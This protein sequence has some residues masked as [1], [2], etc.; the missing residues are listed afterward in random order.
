MICKNHNAQQ[1][2]TY[3]V[4][5]K[6]TT[7]YEREDSFFFF[8]YGVELNR[9]SFELE[10]SAGVGFDLNPEWP[11]EEMAAHSAVN[12]GSD[13]PDENR[14]DISRPATP[15]P[16][17]T[18]EEGTLR[19]SNSAPMF[20]GPN[21]TDD[22]PVFQPIREKPR[23]RRMSAQTSDGTKPVSMPVR[24]P[25]RVSQIKQEE[26]LDIMS[27]EAEHEREVRSAFRISQS[28][29]ELHLDE[30]IK[31]LR[32][33]T[34]SSLTEPLS[35]ITPVPSLPFAA[36]SP[37]PT[38]AGKQCFSPQ[39]SM[40]SPCMSPS[41]NPSPTRSNFTR[42]SMSPVL[43]PSSLTSSLKRKYDSD[44]EYTPSKRQLLSSPLHPTS[45]SMSSMS[46]DETSPPQRIVAT[47]A[48]SF[49]AAAAA[50]SSFSPTTTFDTS[51]L[52]SSACFSFSTNSH[53]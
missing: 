13:S 24:I 1:Y 5:K 21:M 49:A 15:G 16:I 46:S 43:R 52:N 20:N 35:I 12:S 25:S 29:D 40:R 32:S 47:Q 53:A 4:I 50:A 22:S 18:R 26:T 8:T 42:R 17:S 27:K 30:S 38:R 7:L 31:A 48:S 2:P 36:S 23:V 14:M 34:R 33:D 51:G 6:G 3:S 19:R 41:P 9:S 39:I 11:D 28:C 37:S 45:L 44:G 10:W